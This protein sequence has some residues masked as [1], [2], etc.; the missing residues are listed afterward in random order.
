MATDIPKTLKFIGNTV[1]KPNKDYFYDLMIVLTQTPDGPPP[2]AAHEAISIVR[3]RN[4]EVAYNHLSL[5]IKKV[6]TRKDQMK[7]AKI[8][9]NFVHDFDRV[10]IYLDGWTDMFN[11][12]IYDNIAMNCRRGITVASEGGFPVYNRR[13]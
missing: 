1:Y 6:L 13:N 3:V 12:E 11:I 5:V 7:M 4:F 8:H 10:G 2:W 9:H